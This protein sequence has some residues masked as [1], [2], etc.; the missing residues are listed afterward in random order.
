MAQY[1]TTGEEL[2]SIANAIRAKTG[3]NSPLVYPNGFV[4]AINGMEWNWVG[5]NPELIW[6]SEDYNIAFA[7]TL[8]PTW[9]PSTTAFTMYDSVICASGLTLDSTKHYNI[10]FETYVNFVYNTNPSVAY[11]EQTYFI[12]FHNFGARPLN[13]ESLINNIDD[14][15]TYA[16]NGNMH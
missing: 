1:I 15:V 2:T 5:A 12:G 9:T 13:V 10:V 3:E 6:E 7:D 8:L 14:W 4:N 11:T 16:V